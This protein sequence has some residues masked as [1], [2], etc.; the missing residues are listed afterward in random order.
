MER[1]CDPGTQL[2]DD[3]PQVRRPYLRSGGD[4]QLRLQLALVQVGLGF[5]QT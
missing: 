1:L 4:R 3:L 5:Q 2:A